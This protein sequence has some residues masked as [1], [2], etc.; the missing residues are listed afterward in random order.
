MPRKGV[1]SDRT[2]LSVSEQTFDHC[3][4]LYRAVLQMKDATPE[5]RCFAY[6]SWL[7]LYARNMDFFD[8]PREVLLSQ[9]HS[10]SFPG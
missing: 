7:L 3:V 2:D 1:S 9:Y 5:D 8:E 4:A 10:Y 6:Y